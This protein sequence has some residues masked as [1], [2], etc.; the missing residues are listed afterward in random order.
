MSSI[1]NFSYRQQLLFI[2]KVA[3]EDPNYGP[4]DIKDIIETVYTKFRYLL[5][6]PPT[7]KLSE[8]LFGM[9]STSKSI[10]YEGIEKVLRSESEIMKA[11]TLQAKL[12]PNQN[13]AIILL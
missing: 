4:N 10:D 11:M 6:N 1:S 2:Y 5:S 12:M 9:S 8:K 7:L 13:H 3:T